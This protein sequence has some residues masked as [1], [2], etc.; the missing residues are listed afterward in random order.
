MGFGNLFFSIL[1]ILVVTFIPL[2]RVFLLGQDIPLVV[3]SEEKGHRDLRTCNCH[4]LCFVEIGLILFEPL[5]HTNTPHVCQI[6]FYVHWGTCGTINTSPH[7]LHAFQRTG[8]N[9]PRQMMIPPRPT[10]HETTFYERINEPATSSTANQ[11][12]E[13]RRIGSTA[14]ISATKNGVLGSPNPAGFR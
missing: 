4:L 11:P 5:S 8:K 12:F 10:L 14:A 2:E 9:F 13:T 6:W 7:A 3:N 1:G